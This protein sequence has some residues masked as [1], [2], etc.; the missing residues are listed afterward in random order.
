MIRSQIWICALPM[1]PAGKLS[2]KQLLHPFSCILKFKWE[3]KFSTTWA[4]AQHF[5]KIACA[6]SEDSDQP[7]HPR[8]LIR[9]LAV[10]LKTLWILGYPRSASR[11]LRSDCADAH[12]Q[13]RRKRCVPVYFLWGSSFTYFTIYLNSYNEQVIY[14]YAYWT[15]TVSYYSSKVSPFQ[16]V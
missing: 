10:R 3:S 4:G 14:W 13:S 6:P 12:M 2:I 15:K 1:K 9:V 8:S 7:A 16:W 5:L 11:K